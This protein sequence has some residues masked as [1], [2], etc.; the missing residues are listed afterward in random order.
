MLVTELFVVVL[1]IDHVEWILRKNT[2][3]VSAQGSWQWVFHVLHVPY[4]PQHNHRCLD[5]EIQSSIQN[6]DK[7]LNKPVGQRQIRSSSKDIVT[8]LIIPAAEIDSPFREVVQAVLE[9]WPKVIRL[10]FPPKR[11]SLQ[12]QASE[13]SWAVSILVRGSW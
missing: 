10:P 3:T 2:G 1:M 7:P 8:L 5:I 4:E 13:K 9:Y 11:S 12:P 6:I